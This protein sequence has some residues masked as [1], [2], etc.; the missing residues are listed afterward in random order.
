MFLVASCTTVLKDFET[1]LASHFRRHRPSANAEMQTAFPKQVKT[2][3]RKARK[4]KDEAGHDYT[5]PST[6]FFPVDCDFDE[7]LQRV[8]NARVARAQS[9]TSPNALLSARTSSIVSERLLAGPSSQTWTN[10]ARSLRVL[11][12]AAIYEEE[13]IAQTREATLQLHPAYRLRLAVSA[14]LSLA[15]IEGQTWSWLDNHPDTEP[16]PLSTEAQQRQAELLA[17]EN[18]RATTLNVEGRMKR[19]LAPIVKDKRLWEQG[20]V[21]PPVAQA[22]EVFRKVKAIHPQTDHSF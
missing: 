3:T 17:A 6:D 2:S 10:D 14:I 4:G 19:L 18:D 20:T 16:P 5:P 1:A 15:T 12:Q 11:H 22:M 7:L 13:Y 8:E 9:R 21:A